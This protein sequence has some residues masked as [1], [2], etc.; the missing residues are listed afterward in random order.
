MQIHG[1]S[2]ELEALRPRSSAPPSRFM[3]A[4]LWSVGE[5]DAASYPISGPALI[6]LA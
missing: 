4:R 2:F 6:V 1:L 3:C 5:R